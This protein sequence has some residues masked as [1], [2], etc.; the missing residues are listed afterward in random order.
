MIT[1]YTIKDLKKALEYMELK[2]V[3]SVVGLE[4]DEMGRMHISAYDNSSNHVKI[5]IYRC[6]GQDG[7]KMPDITKTERL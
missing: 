4:I 1:K 2:L 7:T 5:T 3:A 6:D